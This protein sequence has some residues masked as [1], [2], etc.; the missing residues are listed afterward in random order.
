MIPWSWDRIFRAARKFEAS[1][2]HMIRGLCPAVRVGGSINFL[3]GEPLQPE[4]LENLVLGM[5][6]DV[7]KET[8]AK[9]WQLCFSRHWPEV[10][11]F[12]ASVYM[13]AGIPEAAIR[14]CE[15]SVRTREELRLPEK[16]DEIA[17]AATGLVLIT[18]PTGA[19]KT[20]TLNYM[21]DLINQER[22]AKI[23]TI[24]DPIEY[25]HK[26]RRSIIV[27]QEV[28]SD[29]LSFRKALIHALRQN[30]DVLVVGEMRDLETMETALTAA[31]TGHL[32]I[33]TLHTPDV[34]QTVQR[35]FSVFPGEQQNHVVQQLANSLQAV[36]CQRLLP[37]AGGGGR[38]L[39]TEFCVIT[40]GIRNRIRDMEAH[41]I[42][43]EMQVGA[44][45][46]M[47]TMDKNL[48]E[49]YQ[50]GDITYDVA[51][52]NAREPDT[53]RQRSA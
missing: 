47:H 50:R 10:G 22:R 9:E 25:V 4:T 7:Q 43:S 26:H 46:G 11:R 17:R 33:A 38:V 53:I 28:G 27:Q 24:E 5:L 40:S 6:N 2:I 44:K 32:V 29:V 51:V 39:A 3:E 37:R 12:R 13:N 52:S 48:L 14:L 30:P 35:I 45:R 42:Y 23:I 16:I 21:V 31:E 18:G 1:D 15:T 36:L 8:L 49:L 19:G 34:V 20:T 41:H